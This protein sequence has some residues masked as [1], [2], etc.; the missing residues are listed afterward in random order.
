[1]NDIVSVGAYAH[2][3]NVHRS[4]THDRTV[5]AAVVERAHAPPAMTLLHALHSQMPTLVRLT[6]SLPQKVHVY[7]ECCEISIFLTD[8]RSEEPRCAREGGRGL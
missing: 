6:E 5:A 3:S 7:L 2:V 8:R 4:M 1:M